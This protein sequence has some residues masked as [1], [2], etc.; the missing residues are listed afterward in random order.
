MKNVGENLCAPKF[1]EYFGLIKNLLLQRVNFRTPRAFVRTYGCQQNVSDSEKINGMLLAMG[2]ALAQDCEDTDIIVFNT[3][4]VREN[5][6]D[7]VFG[8]VGALKAL[9]KR[10]PDLIIVLCGC[11][12]EQAHVVERL[13]QSFP[14]VDLVLG[15]NSLERFPELIYKILTEKKHIW[16]SKTECDTYSADANAGNVQVC[17][18]LPIER[19]SKIKA[20]LPIMYG[21]DNFC[22]YCVV[23]HVRGR[24]KSRSAKAICD[25]FS[26]LIGNGY[27]EVTLLGQNVNSYGKNLDE[28]IDFAQLLRRLDRTPGG[29]WLRFMTSHPKDATPKLIN[30]MAAGEHICHHLHLPFQAGSDRVL[31]LMNRGYTRQ[32]YLEIISYAKAKMPDVCLT[33]DVIVGFPGERYEDFCETLSL[34]KEVGFT[35]LFTFIYSK[36]SGTPAAEMDDPISEKEKSAWFREL[37]EVQNEITTRQCQKYDG[38]V[39]KVLIEGKST[40]EGALTTRTQGNMIVDIAGEEDLVGKFAMVKVTGIKNWFLTGEITAIL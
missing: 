11:M 12:T 5:A 3:C 39:V 8:N 9:K 23:P 27:K 28:R 34:I 31:K 14:F 10:N 17:E 33:S 37:L 21:C 40:K 38:E 35:S 20:F 7:R 19:A 16:P 25:E 15:T 32:G 24:E 6:E 2:C 4:A 36:R 1:E 18:G 22:S 29:Y 13:K 26:Q 30:V